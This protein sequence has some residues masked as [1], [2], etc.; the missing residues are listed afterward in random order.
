[1]RVLNKVTLE[2]RTVACGGPAGFSYEGGK[3][4]LSFEIANADDALKLL[5]WFESQKEPLVVNGQTPEQVPVTDDVA[6][7]QQAEPSESS[8]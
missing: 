4:S 7:A 8:N 6:A 5:A 2:G 1:M 3:F